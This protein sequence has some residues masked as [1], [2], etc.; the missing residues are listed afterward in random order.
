[1]STDLNLCRFWV[2]NTPMVYEV[3]KFDDVWLGVESRDRTFKRWA[4]ILVSFIFHFAVFIYVIFGPMLSA[5]SEMPELKVVDVYL[6]HAPPK[7]PASMRGARKRTQKKTKLVKKDKKIEKK[8]PESVNTLI[9]PVEVPGEIVDEEE[10]FFESNLDFGPGGGVE[11]GGEFGFDD[12]V[13]GGSILGE[14][15][16]T[17]VDPVRLTGKFP[18]RIKYVK[19]DYPPEALASRKT[20]SVVVETTFDAYG[21]AKKWRVIVVT[22]HE[23][24]EPAAI[25][26]IK[27]WRY[28]PY[29]VNGVPTP[30]II[31]VTVSF[32][33][34]M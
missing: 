24:F 7:P 14:I 16:E 34:A 28:E 27:Q 29:I 10:E 15:G 26:A 31:T 3:P 23:L 19:P 2:I 6:S 18:K 9:V 4:T 8:L 33:K 12:G 17:E 21:K 13:I 5:G 20:G 11:G 1:M 25:D 22:G 30:F 32:D